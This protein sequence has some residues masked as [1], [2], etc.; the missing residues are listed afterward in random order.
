[1]QRLILIMMMMLTG[2]CTGLNDSQRP[3]AAE[4]E[5][6][7]VAFAETLVEAG[8]PLTPVLTIDDGVLGVPDHVY[9][10]P[11]QSEI[12]IFQFLSDSA[13]VDAAEEISPDGSL[14]GTKKVHWIAPP[15]YYRKGRTILVQLGGDDTLSTTLEQILGPPFATQ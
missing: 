1:M 3:S 10:L 13:A 15:R 8:I 6:V 2:A 5:Q 9:E 12:R 14:I 11:D 7:S 4:G